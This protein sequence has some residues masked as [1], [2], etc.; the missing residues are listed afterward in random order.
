[1]AVEVVGWSSRSGARDPGR[2]RAAELG[3]DF[4]ILKNF[5]H[6]GSIAAEQKT[7]HISPEPGS[8]GWKTRTKTDFQP[9]PMKSSIV[10]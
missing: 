1:M 4:F 9:G 8:L 10:V 2:G 3:P 6:P 5:I 7:I